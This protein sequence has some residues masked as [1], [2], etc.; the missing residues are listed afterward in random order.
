LEFV[1]NREPQGCF[2][3]DVQ[4]LTDIDQDRVNDALAAAHLYHPDIGVS[5]AS[6]LDLDQAM[7]NAG[8]EVRFEEILPHFNP[9]GGSEEPLDDS[10]AAVENR[11]DVIKEANLWDDHEGLVIAYPCQRAEDQ[12]PFLHFIAAI[13]PQEGEA[14]L[15]VMDP[16]ELPG[17]GGVF[18]RSEEEVRKLLTPRPDLGI[19]VCAYLVK[20]DVLP[21][22]EGPRSLQAEA[23]PGFRAGVFDSSAG[24]A[25]AIIL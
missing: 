16:S 20:L 2:G 10:A 23:D 11:L 3:A 4:A 15:T 13:E 25:P 1:E 12:P 17:V 7:K 6:D 9:F 14:G 8:L 24:R 5:L 22:P 19:P 18:Q 21:I